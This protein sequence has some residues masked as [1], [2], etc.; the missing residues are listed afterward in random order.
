MANC[1]E[2]NYLQALPQYRTELAIQKYGKLPY[3][4]TH[5]DSDSARIR[6]LF[7]I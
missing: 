1:L 2:L 7:Y 6:I 5:P 4:H 3:F